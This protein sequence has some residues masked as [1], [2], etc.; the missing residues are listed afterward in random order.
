[1]TWLPQESYNWIKYESAACLQ[2]LQSSPALRHDSKLL[3]QKS[4]IECKTACPFHVF[5]STVD[6]PDEQKKTAACA[7]IQTGQPHLAAFP[8]QIEMKHQDTTHHKTL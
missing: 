7:D 5:G 4:G 1:M 2:Q 6:V 3:V 8:T